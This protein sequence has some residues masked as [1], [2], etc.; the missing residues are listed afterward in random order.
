MTRTFD[1]PAFLAQYRRRCARL[2]ID[3]A[4]GA[5][6]YDLARIRAD[7]R[8][9]AH[10]PDYWWRD[11]ALWTDSAPHRSETEEEALARVFRQ[12]FSHVTQLVAGQQRQR[13]ALQ[14]R[15]KHQSKNLSLRELLAGRG[16]KLVWIDA[17]DGSGAT[18]VITVLS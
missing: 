11:Y 4:A 14:E 12:A 7:A 9:A 2:G 3:S 13:E 8:K 18:S 1:Y 6:S 15:W 17:P 10:I 5:T 16:E